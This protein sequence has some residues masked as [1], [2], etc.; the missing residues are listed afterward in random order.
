MY[1]FNKNI[2]TVP[3][4]KK[5]ME[6]SVKSGFSVI[7]QK[8]SLTGLKVVFG[9]FA[10]PAG[11]TIYVNSE[12]MATQWANKVFTVEGESIIL[13]PEDEIKLINIPDHTPY[14][15]NFVSS[16]ANSIYRGEF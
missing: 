14:N 8:S 9:T 3:F 5:S 2:A 11:S 4:E 16:P 6:S 10:V 12:L 1:S 13:V 15:K 7:A